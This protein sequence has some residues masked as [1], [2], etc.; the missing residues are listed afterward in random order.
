MENGMESQL[1]FQTTY[2]QMLVQIART[3]PPDRVAEL[4]DF[5]RFLQSLATND[6]S[7]WDQ[8]FAKPDAQRVMLQMAREAREDYRAGRATDIVITEDGRLA[9]K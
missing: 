4:L 1:E 6:E 7:E 2:E 9:P 3:L 5:A 8:L